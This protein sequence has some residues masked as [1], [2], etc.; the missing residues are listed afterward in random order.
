MKTGDAQTNEI[1]TV[2]WEFIVVGALP[3]SKACRN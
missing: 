1:L 2:S 3:C